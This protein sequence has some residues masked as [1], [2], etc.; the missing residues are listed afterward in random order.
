[1]AFEDLLVTLRDDEFSKLRREKALQ[2]S[3]AAQFVNL[4]GDPR[5]QIAVQLP[6]LLG[7]LAQFAQQPRVLHRDDRL[8]CKVLQQRNLLVREGADFLAINGQ[9][10]EQ[11][12]L[13]PQS[14]REQA[15]APA[16]ID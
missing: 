12:V 2:P 6:D 8:G 13:F 9:R 11:N 14:N 7:A 3:D 5:L 10:T 1:M 16:V 15:S 4:L